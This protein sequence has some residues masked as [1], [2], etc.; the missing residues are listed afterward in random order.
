[1]PE[2]GGSDIAASQNSSPKELRLWMYELRPALLRVQYD[3]QLSNQGS[4]RSEMA[5]SVEGC[6]HPYTSIHLTTS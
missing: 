5:V 6:H 1:M 4:H 2:A 3:A